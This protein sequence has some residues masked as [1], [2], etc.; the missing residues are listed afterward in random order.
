MSAKFDPVE[1]AKIKPPPGRGKDA[2]PAAQAAA[3]AQAEE[4]ATP[5][6]EPAKPQPPVGEVLA[7]PLGARGYT[8]GFRLYRVAK[9]KAF[10]WAG[11]M[12]QLQAGAIV[13]PSSFG[14]APGLDRLA[15]QGVEL[16]GVE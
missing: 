15:A 2:R 16:V 5:A 1:A 14:G 10:S 9:T 13:D 7:R 8:P 6:L 3:T 11:N 12:T 4:P